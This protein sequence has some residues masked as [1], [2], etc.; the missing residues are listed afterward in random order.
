MQFGLL[1]SASILNALARVGVISVVMH[2]YAGVPADFYLLLLN[3][4]YFSSAISDFGLRTQALSD[5]ARGIVSD[6]SR[7]LREIFVYRLVAGIAS[8]ILYL[9]IVFSTW[10]SKTTS[11]LVVIGVMGLYGALMPVADTALTILRGRQMI[12]TDSTIR[13]AENI[14]GLLGCLA[15]ALLGYPILAVALVL[16]GLAIVRQI[17]SIRLVGLRSLGGSISLSTIRQQLVRNSPAGFSLL[18]MTAGQRAPV[19]LASTF[20]LVDGVSTLAVVMTIAISS[21]VFSTSAANFLI[22]RL[23]ASD[24]LLDANIVAKVVGFL[25]ITGLAAGAVLYFVRS[26]V[27]SFFNAEIGH[28]FYLALIFAISLTMV[29]DFLRFYMVAIEKAKRFVL[30]QALALIAAFAIPV[31]AG[32][33]TSFVAFSWAFV[34]YLG[35]AVVISLLWLK[36]SVL[37]KTA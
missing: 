19:L 21:Q 33:T 25:A 36:F 28:E 23:I 30:V 9:G 2:F 8:I 27:N 32:I 14:L 11:E 6:R 12:A 34:G 4:A 3:A 1:L 24:R 26:L 17:L 29:F 31:A 13:I 35:I 15:V 5:G 7:L 10:Q 22:P 16:F 37:K 20:Y 18:A